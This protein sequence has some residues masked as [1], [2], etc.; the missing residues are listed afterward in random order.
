MKKSKNI[1][2]M[3]LA[4][5]MLLSCF[6]TTNAFA[7]DNPNSEFTFAPSTTDDPEVFSPAEMDEINLDYQSKAEALLEAEQSPTDGQRAVAYA[8]LPT[9]ASS[10]TVVTGNTPYFTGNY[11]LNAGSAGYVRFTPT[12]SYYTCVYTTGSTDTYIEV[13]TNSACTT[14]V[15]YNDDSG[16]GLNACVYFYANSGTTYY[17]K[18]RGYSTSTSG[19]YF[20]VLHRGQP[21][22]RSEKG[23]LFTT[24]NSSTYQ[25]Y[26]NCYTYA[27]SYYVN[28][29]TGYKFSYGG[30]N[31]GAMGGSSIT[32]S[33][34]VN[35]TTAKTKIEA[36]LTKDFNYFGG[37]W[38]EISASD[39]PRAGY[40]KVALVLAPGQ[41]YH[42]YRQI[43][44]GTFTHKPSILAA[45][46][47]DS[48]NYLIYQPNT[49]NRDGTQDSPPT[50]NYTN[51]IAFYEF[52]VPA[53]VSPKG[54]ISPDDAGKNEYPLMNNLTIDDVMTLSSGMSA[55]KAMLVLGQAHGYFGSGMIGNVY[56]LTDG[57]TII[58]YFNN[59]LLD[60]VHIL[61]EDNSSKV[62]IE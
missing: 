5:V 21:T 42:W 29:K 14:R 3:L 57:T 58:V 19:D 16:D 11:T 60:Q 18:L 22:S 28:P 6:I 46:D 36:A 25:N 10:G 7:L 40:F 32:L 51:F 13:F 2:T 35:A 1:L 54:G 44:G 4:T 56:E 52:K 50:P 41:D 20:F 23:N 47:Y 62:I 55:E 38:K 30:T 61:N 24:Y 33:D 12:Q 53:S 9:S 43:P 17:V 26:N 15:A 39:Q 48:S 27:L 49:C 59:D 31:P 8:S 45:R 37:S 34:L